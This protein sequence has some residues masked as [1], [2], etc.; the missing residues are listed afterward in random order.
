MTKLTLIKNRKNKGFSLLEILLV[1]AIAAALVIGAF[2]VYPK[3]QAGAR[4]DAE[5]KNISTIVAGIKSLYTSSSTYAGLT[6]TVAANAKIF[7]D[8]MLNGSSTTPINAWKG[9]VT[10]AAANTGPSSATGS[11]FT[12]QYLAVPAAECAKI[13]SGLAGNFYTVSVDSTAV[14]TAGGTLDVAA[15]TKACNS[16]R[17]S[18]TLL[19]TSL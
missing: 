2:I 1:L 18:N 8:N 7:P 9:N 3:V 17:N 4:A 14:K 12:I 5:S 10:V 15:M 19:F 13:V 6:N 11:S 16:G